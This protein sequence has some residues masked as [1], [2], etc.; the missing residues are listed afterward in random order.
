ML[1]TLNVFADGVLLVCT[2]VTR[3]PCWLTNK[4]FFPQNLHENEFSSQRK[5][6][7]LFLS[8]D[9]AAVRSSANQLILG[10]L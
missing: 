10:S 3:Q 1:V 5:K 8:A 7:F 2:Q 4:L 6:T 9:M